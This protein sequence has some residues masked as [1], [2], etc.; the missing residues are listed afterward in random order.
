MNSIDHCSTTLPE[1]VRCETI[2]YNKSV[3]HISLHL[4]NQVTHMNSENSRNLLPL[5]GSLQW[6]VD[7][8]ELSRLQ[9]PLDYCWLD[10]MQSA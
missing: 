3:G 5:R 8:V 9:L 1:M 10:F 6:P 2:A 4:T 7:S